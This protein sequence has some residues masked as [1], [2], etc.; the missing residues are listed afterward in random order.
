MPLR[1]TK[2]V[3]VALIRLDICAIEKDGQSLK[4]SR[5]PVVVSA[6]DAGHC[7]IDRNDGRGAITAEMSELD[8]LKAHCDFLI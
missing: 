4:D 3:H 1:Q 6:H 2:T 8:G 5:L 7:G